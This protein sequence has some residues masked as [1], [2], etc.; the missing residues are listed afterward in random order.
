MVMSEPRD[1]ILQPRTK[2]TELFLEEIL[3]R[4]G[5]LQM[6]MVILPKKGADSG[7]GTPSQYSTSKH[8]VLTVL[9]NH[10]LV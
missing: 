8:F 7:Y 10:S 2:S 6:I 4:Q 5:D 1:V 9:L 3:S